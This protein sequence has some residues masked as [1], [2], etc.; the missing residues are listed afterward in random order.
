MCGGR[1]RARQPLSAK[2]CEGNRRC[3][4]I[5]TAKSASH[6]E[7]GRIG[8]SCDLRKQS[9]DDHHSIT[10]R[11]A[12]SV[13]RGP[14]DW[15]SAAPRR[16]GKRGVSKRGVSERGTTI[17]RPQ[18]F[19]GS[20]NRSARPRNAIGVAAVR[21]CWGAVGAWVEDGWK[22]VG[23]WGQHRPA[24]RRLWREQ[25]SQ[26]PVL[27][28]RVVAAAVGRM[29]H[30]RTMLLRLAAVRR[31]HRVRTCSV[32]TRCVRVT[33][34][35]VEVG[36]Q[37]TTP[38][39]ALG[40]ALEK[41]SYTNSDEFCPPLRFNMRGTTQ[42]QITVFTVAVVLCLRDC[43]QN[44]DDPEPRSG[45]LSNATPVDF[46]APIRRRSALSLRPYACTFERWQNGDRTIVNNSSKG[47][48]P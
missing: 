20:H 5:A 33:A 23:A 4:L 2:T 25:S 15:C 35:S 19:G 21:K 34:N 22:V 17:A 26:V 37:T 1:A 9:S 31:Q 32:H 3:P 47:L 7:C 8:R 36:N 39:P 38:Y 41:F 13:V 42:H 16:G 14:H 27:S 46:R 45:L 18:H 29:I 48:L 40:T 28:T 12:R 30:S 11:P 43:R 44:R 6:R 10:G 24:T